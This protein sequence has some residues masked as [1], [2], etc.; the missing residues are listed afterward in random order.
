MIAIAGGKG[1]C[2]KT[3]TTLVLSR[4]MASRGRGRILAVDADW[5]MPDLHSLAGVDPLAPSAT[6]TSAASVRRLTSVSAHGVYVLPAPTGEDLSRAATVFEHVGA[7]ARRGDVARTL[8]DCP[9]GVGRDVAV[10]LDVATETVLVSTG[11]PA[12]LRDAA[13]TAAMSRTLGTPISCA[14]ITG[15]GEIPAGVDQLLGTD[16]VVPVPDVDSPLTSARARRAYEAA[17]RIV[18]RT[19]REFG[20]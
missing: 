9:A 2:G 11:E 15:V 10:P 16:E 7:V 19:G 6:V 8:L 20:K 3:T 18:E 5:D 14:V 13:K 1:G 12:S 17:A 4:A